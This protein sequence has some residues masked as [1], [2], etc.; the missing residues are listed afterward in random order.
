MIRKAIIVVLTLGAVGMFVLGGSSYFAATTFD[1]RTTDYDKLSVSVTNLAV[2]VWHKHADYVLSDFHR[3][4]FEYELRGTDDHWRFRV[5]GWRRFEYDDF[6]FT[7][8]QIRFVFFP[9]WVP[10]ILFAAYP[11]LAFIRGPLR[12]NRRRKRGLCMKCGYDLR[13]SP[14]RKCSECGS[15]RA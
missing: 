8:E 10:A 6:L 9:F 13:G 3:T 4:H 7:G 2:S 14:E 1:W 11:A 15:E 5:N 12:R